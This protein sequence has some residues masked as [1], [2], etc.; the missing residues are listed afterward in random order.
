MATLIFFLTLIAIIVFTIQIIIK[1]FKHKSIK[2]S[3]R[4][5]I[6]V[7][8]AYSFLW[9][10]FY[11]K[12]SKIIVPLGTDICFDDWCATITKVEQMKTLGNEKPKGQFIILNIRMSNHARGIAQK[13][14]EPRVHIFDGQGHFYSI[15]KRGQKALERLIGKQLPLDEMLELHQSLETQ[16]VFDIPSDVKGANGLIEEGPFIT[17]LLFQ[18][19]KQVF[20]LQY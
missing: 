3:L 1:L 20:K 18:N 8:T 16:L 19:N 13:P 4:L 7:I 5:L 10:F 2:S 6:I 15:S 17:K 9:I 12:S 14:S 11:F